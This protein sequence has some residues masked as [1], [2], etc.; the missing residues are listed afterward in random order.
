VEFHGNM[1]M[2]S[3]FFKYSEKNSSRYNQK[4]KQKG[5]TPNNDGGFL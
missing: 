5:I 2:K 1:G 4:S 3:F